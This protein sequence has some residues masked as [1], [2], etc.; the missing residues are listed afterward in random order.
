[1]FYNKTLGLFINLIKFTNCSFIWCLF[2]NL[3]RHYVFKFKLSFHEN[4]IFKFFSVNLD[5]NNHTFLF[6]FVKKYFCGVIREPQLFI[7][8]CVFLLLF[9]WF[10]VCLFSLVPYFFFF[11]SSLF[12][13]HIFI[14]YFVSLLFIFFLFFF[15][16][17]MFNITWF[18]FTLF[19]CRIVEVK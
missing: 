15:S 6:N 11:L 3:L 16:F 14:P 7:C 5:K 2:V 12:C 10:F 8:V 17:F 19:I 1:M 4:F 9:F 13:F 18:I